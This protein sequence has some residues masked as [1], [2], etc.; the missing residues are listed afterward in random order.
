MAV[1]ECLFF[2]GGLVTYW[3]NLEADSGGSIE[4]ILFAKIADEEWQAAEAWQ[5]DV[6]VCR[7]VRPHYAS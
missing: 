4:A 2:T 6:L 3:E 7:A 5:D 1:Y